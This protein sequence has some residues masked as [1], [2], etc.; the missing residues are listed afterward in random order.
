MTTQTLQQCIDAH[1][2]TAAAYRKS[3]N[4]LLEKYG[5][6]VRPSWV[7]EDLERDYD[8]ARHHQAE[9]DRLG[10]QLATDDADEYLNARERDIF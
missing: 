7:S 8:S 3:A 5:Q 6:G 2:V 1:I 9:A 4:T 10:L